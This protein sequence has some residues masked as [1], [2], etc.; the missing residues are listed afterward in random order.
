MQSASS[1]NEDLSKLLEAAVQTQGRGAHAQ[2]ASLARQALEAAEAAGLQQAAARA[3]VTLALSLVRLGDIE[4]AVAC[5]QAALGH[6]QAH[7]PPS[8]HAELLAMMSLAFERAGLAPFAAAHA[9]QALEVARACGDGV[10]ECWALI[11]LATAVHDVDGGQRSQALMQQ[12]LEQARTLPNPELAFSALNNSAR[13]WVVEADRLAEVGDNPRPALDR[14]LLPAQEAALLAQSSHQPFWQLNAASNLGGIC[15]RLCAVGQARVH[16]KTALALAEGSGARA[17][18]ATLRL[19]LACLDV[20]ESASAETCAAL[21]SMLAVPAEGTDHDLLHQARRTLVQGLRQMG[22][23]TRALEHLE[24]LHVS[25]MAAHVRKADLQARLLFSRAELEQARHQ[26]ERARL[27]A[28]VQRL[29]AEAARRAKASFLAVASHELRT[30]LNGVLGLVEVARRRTSDPGLQR[31]LDMA[32][33]AGRGLN[34]LLAQLLEYVAVDE[35]PLQAVAPF[36]LRRLMQQ[37]HHDMLPA[38]HARG[39]GVV[40]DVSDQVPHMLLLDAERTRRVL[41]VL[42]DNV[43]KFATRGPIVLS[44]AWQDGWLRLEVADA[45]PGIAP[46]VQQRLFQLF[47]P[48]DPSFARAHGGLGL[49]LALARRL[50]LAMG[51]TV[52]VDSGLG[53]GSTFHARWP[54]PAAAA[55]S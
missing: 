10:A 6:L 33:E 48:G 9:A 1:S 15:R 20:E 13:L 31:H 19:A 29:R 5:G 24:R 16:F 49:G 50:V 38:A 4:A 40:L 47:E 26:A 36:D 34:A 42:L 12:A 25:T 41:E 52:G 3:R 30:P 18:V 21:E 8:L 35:H 43:L 22:D 53:R 51:G 23:L 44:A 55:D 17:E 37:M 28:E 32:A 11:R 46:E 14:A 45:G 54:A 2:A 39:L 7:G 27:D